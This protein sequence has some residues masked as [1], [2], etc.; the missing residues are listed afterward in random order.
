MFKLGAR[1]GLRDP[2]NLRFG[3]YIKTKRILPEIP[4]KIDWDSDV[5]DKYQMFGNDLAG[6]CVFVAA[7]NQI[8][9]SAV[10]TGDPC[11]ITTGKVLR[12]Y[13]DVT[14]YDPETGANDRGSFPEDV[15]RHLSKK[16]IGDPFRIEAW[17][18]ID[19]SNLEEIR[20]GMYLFGGIFTALYLPITARDQIENGEV[21]HINRKTAFRKRRAGSWG[22]HMTMTRFMNSSE[23]DIDIR[24][25]TWARQQKMTEEWWR[26]YC[27]VAY[28]FITEK[29]I[30]DHTGKTPA[31]F[32]LETL[33]ADVEELRK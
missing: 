30:S 3:N 28:F 10:K 24:T 22:G 13:S 18:E 32:D 19:I 29:W 33:L 31:G 23:K 20:A 15:L 11:D 2:R 1:L 8:V 27:A 21:W 6:N 5:M 16:P 26:K 12:E 9:G 4:L 25:I 14:G 17:G 7:A